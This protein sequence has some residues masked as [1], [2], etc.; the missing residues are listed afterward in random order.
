MKDCETLSVNTVNSELVDMR[1]TKSESDRNR[2]ILVAQS[3]ESR[4]ADRESSSL[5]GTVGV[6]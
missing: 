6:S 5:F 2:W 1:G 4:H 3:V